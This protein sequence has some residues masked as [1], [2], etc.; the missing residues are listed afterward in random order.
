M[1]IGQAKF[2]LL[3]GVDL[4]NLDLIQTQSFSGV[5]NVDFT[6]IKETKYDTHF[7]TVNNCTVTTSTESV[8]LRFYESGVLETAA[9]YQIAF[10]NRA[11]DS[12]YNE[13]TSTGVNR[14]YGTTAV[15]TGSADVI[16]GYGFIYNAGNAN[17]Y[18]SVNIHSTGI[19]SIL[20][21]RYGGG[22]ITQSSVVD[23]FRFF[24]NSGNNMSGKISL[25][26]VLN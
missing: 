2:G 23:G 6:S 20:E 22:T 5:V 4:G 18:T 11:T 26:G 25:Y 9:V 21:C 16:T 13:T 8:G 7:Y 14:I 12:T 1:P 24:N 17:K 15:G 3:G 19:D 10:Q